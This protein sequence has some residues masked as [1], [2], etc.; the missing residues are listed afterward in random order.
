MQIRKGNLCGRTLKAYQIWDKPNSNDIFKSYLGYHDLEGLH[1]SPNYF[2]RLWKKL[3]V[4]IQQLGPPTF[5]V[6]FTSTKRL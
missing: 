2:E 4:M 6:T 3:F 1:N 5:F